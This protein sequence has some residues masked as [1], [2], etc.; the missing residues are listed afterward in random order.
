MIST[1]NGVLLFPHHH[2][3]LLYHVVALGSNRS[4]DFG[5]YIRRHCV[6][7]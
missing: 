5:N 6:K 1:E 4:L 7:W 3:L 2:K